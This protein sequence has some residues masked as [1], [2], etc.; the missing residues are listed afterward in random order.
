[1]AEMSRIQIESVEQSSDTGGKCIVRCVGGVPRVGDVFTSDEISGLALVKVR[2]TL[3]RIERYE[4]RFVQFFDPPHAA[5]IHVSGEG[6][7]LLTR[8]S[9]IT[10]AAESVPPNPS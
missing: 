9:V 2:L 3:D 8:W 10:S 7:G 1:M 6:V 5:R 4:G